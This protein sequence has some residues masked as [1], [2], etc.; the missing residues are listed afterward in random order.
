MAAGVFQVRS[1]L[2][3]LR[4]RFILVDL[5]EIC[6]TITV[7]VAYAGICSPLDQKLDEVQMTLFDSFMQ[8]GVAVLSLC[9]DV[10][11]RLQ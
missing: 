3:A 1:A 9:I 2:K 4:Y 11:A 7:D 10:G 6:R 5:C 8:R